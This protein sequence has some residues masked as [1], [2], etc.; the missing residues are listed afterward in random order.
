MLNVWYRCFYWRLS[1]TVA[2]WHYNVAKMLVILVA[3]NMVLWRT[4]LQCVSV[5]AAYVCVCITDVINA[6]LSMK[7]EL[8]S[9]LTNLKWRNN[10]KFVI[11]RFEKIYYRMVIGNHVL[12]IEWCHFRC[13]WVTHDPDFDSVARVCQ[14]Q[15]G[16]LV[17]TLTK[18][19]V[20][21]TSS[22]SQENDMFSK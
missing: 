8:M 2:C 15:L 17:D 9:S 12:A 14:R 16:F 18:N 13:P 19:N 4:F 11:N 7:F 21:E 10:I 3:K 1:G 5:C 22:I 6:S 20:P